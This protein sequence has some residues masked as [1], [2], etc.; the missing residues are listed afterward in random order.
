[1]QQYLQRSARVSADG[2]RRRRGAVLLLITA[3]VLPLQRSVTAAEQR[4]ERSATDLLWL[5]SMAPQLA[6]LQ[7]S[8]PPPLR[9]SLVVLVDRTARESGLDKSLV[10]GSQPSG[11]GG[12][13]VRFD[14]MPFDS[15][16]AWLSQLRE[17]YGVQVE[18][19]TVDAAN[20]AGT[21]TANPGAAL[22]L[23]SLR[24]AL[25]LAA[26]LFVITLLVRLPASV[27]ASQLPAE[28][29]C[30]EPSGTVWH[31]SC[32][33]VQAGGVSIAGVTWT[34]YP[35][36][37]LSLTLKV[38][39]SSTDPNA[40]GSANIEL[41]R[42]GDAHLSA[43]HFSMPVTPA[44]HL[45]PAGSSATV[46]LAL[47]SATIH[48]QHLAAVEGVVDAAATSHLQSGSGAGQL[49]RCSFRPPAPMRHDWTI[50]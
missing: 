19:A 44:M 34:L 50:A 11:N 20:D 1:M 38:D 2:A 46:I 32:E 5:R 7:A 29:A 41:H 18:S 17:K 8:A 43:V 10:G 27:L 12:L 4:V 15:L 35:L 49:S 26:I 23:M 39:L 47:P 21:V 13:S 36:S 25:I 42:N 16:V 28:L 45:L 22:R 9:E 30:D 3:I 6:M 48:A 31:G 37:L 14:K 40:G 24:I 33:Q